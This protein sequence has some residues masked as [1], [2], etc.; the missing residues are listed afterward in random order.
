MQRRVVVTGLGAVTPLGNDVESTWA[1][2]VE[3]RSGIGPIAA[4]D[5]SDLE[6]RIAGEVKDF[7]ATDYLEPKEAR[8]M[9]RFTHFA[10]AAAMQATKD[11]NLNIRGNN[12]EAVGVAMGSGIGGLRTLVDQVKVLDQKGPRRISPFLVPMMIVNMGAGQVS[13]ALGAKGPNLCVVSACATSA[14]SLGEAFEIIRRS[15]ADVMIAGGSEAPIIPIGVV[16]FIQAQALST[17]RN[18]EPERACRPFDAD[19]DGFVIAEGGAAVVLES[20]EHARE[21]G[22]R[23][24]AEMV[25]YGATADAYHITAPPERGEGA[26]RAM[27]IALRKAGLEPEAVDY[28]NAHGTST[29][30]NDLAETQAMHDVFGEH[31]YKLAVS[32]TKSMTGHLLGAAGALEALVCVK[33]IEQGVIPPTINYEKPDPECDLDYTPNTA[34]RMQ[35]DVAMS[36]SLGFGGHNSCLVLRRFEE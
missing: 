20:L 28:V 7:R 29:P 23:I 3:G 26:A 18:D 11:A 14:H 5:A 21:R 19:R 2:L 1:S 24:Y 4:F 34:R 31:A 15:D 35:V 22:A 27:R 9:D 6:A 8:R 32:S 25:G 33:A 13:I 16:A 10:L 30:L 17:G 12:A 36:N